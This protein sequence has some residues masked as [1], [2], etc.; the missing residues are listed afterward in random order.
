MD[1][2][3]PCENATLPA[4]TSSWTPPVHSKSSR[5]GFSEQDRGG[6]QARH[7]A[8]VEEPR[9]SRHG[10]QRCNSHAFSSPGEGEGVQKLAASSMKNVRPY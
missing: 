6:E 2:A 7:E 9:T 5:G 8:E 1:S 10:R 4:R 3:W